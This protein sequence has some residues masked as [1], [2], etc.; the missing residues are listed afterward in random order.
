MIYEDIKE[1]FNKVIRFS[2]EFPSVN[3]DALFDQWLEAKR[4]I[5]EAFGGKLIYEVAEPVHFHL[6][7][8]NRARAFEEFVMH[9]KNV[10]HNTPLVDFLTANEKGFYDNV[11][12]NP[13][14]YQD[15]KVP[16]GMK[17]VKAFKFF[18][19]DKDVL[20]LLQNLAS[21]VIQE[22]KIEGKLCF[23]VHPLDFL[24]TSMN[25][26]N[27][28]SCHALDGEF[29]AGN[30]SYMV[31]NTTIVC[32]IK[33]ANEAILPLFHPTVLWNSK[34]WRVLLY[35]SE[36]WDMIFASKQYPFT[37]ESGL[38][39]VLTH[40]L[41]AL[42][43]QGFSNWKCQY[44]S[45]VEDKHG[46]RREH[47]YSPYLPIRGKLYPIENIVHDGEHALQFNDLLCSSSYKEPL[48][49]LKEDYV[50]WSAPEQIPKFTIGKQVPCLCCGQNRIKDSNMMACRECVERYDLYYNEE[51]YPICDCCGRRILDGDWLEVEGQI[52]CA[53]CVEQETF[54]CECCDGHYFN[55]RKN[56]DR[57]ADRYICDRCYKLMEDE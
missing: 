31:D 19:K 33:G 24:S 15:I 12:C 50:W 40:L 10:Y 41:S 38:D 1:Q 37:S 32:Y 23:S 54:C 21:Q 8:K 3:S 43:L 18:E 28:R 27:W 51:D 2:Q 20:E 26:Y 17:L 16:T 7:E 25:T 55:E 46:G 13:Y 34:K 56:Y 45:T 47:L 39:V 5:I 30:L 53:T 57:K 11:V 42:K 4:N 36:N 48:F 22:D 52:L 49:S 9:I 44:I 29:R 35:L 6:D 14:E